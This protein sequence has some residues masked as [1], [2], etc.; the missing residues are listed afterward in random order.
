MTH[1]HS[2]YQKIRQRESWAQ[3]MLSFNKDIFFYNIKVLVLCSYRKKRGLRTL[4]WERRS[5]I[6]EEQLLLWQNPL[7]RL[8]LLFRLQYDRTLHIFKFSLHPPLLQFDYAISIQFHLL[9]SGSIAGTGGDG[10]EMDPLLLRLRRFSTASQRENFLVK[11]HRFC[12]TLNGNMKVVLFSNRRSCHNGRSSF[13]WWR[14]NE[15]S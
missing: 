11:I 9:L 15:S 6:L 3:V 4:A 12:L 8:S 5:P 2:G 1:I 7:S 14:I 10:S 13:C